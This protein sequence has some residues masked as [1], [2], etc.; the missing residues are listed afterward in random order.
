MNEA[1]QISGN[2]PPGELERQSPPAILTVVLLYAVFASLWILLSDKAVEWLFRSPAQVILAS[3]LKGWFFVAV[4][5]LLLYGLMRRLLGPRGAPATPEEVRRSLTLPLVLTALAI[6][7][8]TAGGIYHA[9]IHHQDKQAARLQAI[10]DL[11]TRQIADWLKERQG[12]AEF[13]LTSRS[14]AENY[15]RWRDRGEVASRDRLLSRLEEYRKYNAFQSVLL[16]DEQGKCLWCSEG[17]PPEI[18]SLL[19]AI[20]RQASA[21]GRIIRLGPYRDGAGRLHL[22]YA[23]PLPALNGRP[24]PVVVLHLDPQSHLVPILQNWPVPSTSSE[25]LLFRRDGDKILFLNELR[26]QAAAPLKLRLPLEE[27]NLLAARLLRGEIKLGH[28]AKGVDYRGVPVLGVIR[29]VPGTN[30]FLVAKLD[31]AEVYSEAMGDA[32]WIALAGLLALFVAA[33]GAFLYRQRQE[34]AFSQREHRVQ[35]EKLRALQ[36]LEVIADG[37]TDAIFVKDAEGR[38]LLFN[39]EAARVTGRAPEQVLGRDDRTIFPPDQAELIRANDQRV[40]ADDRVVTFQEDLNT[41]DGEASFWATKGPI[42][43]ADARVVGIF[44]ISRDITDLQ[45]ATKNLQENEEKYRLLAENVS[46]VIWVLDL[47]KER[48]RYVSPSVERMGGYTSEEMLSLE[49]PTILTPESLQKFQRVLPE[50]IQRFQ[51][52]YVEFFTD[53]IEQLHQD[54]TR[55]LAE[56]NTR[57]VRN[58]T[59]GHLELVGVTRDITERKKSEQALREKDELLRE[60]SAMAH[61][62]GWS[63]NPI[64]GDGTWTDETARIHD[65]EPPQE[66][67]VPFGLDFFHGE[68]R[69]EL[70]KAVREAG[71]DGRPFDLEL[72]M[73][74]AKGLRKWVRILG[75]PIRLDGRV[76]RVRGT[77]QDITERKRAERERDLTVDLL[78]LVNESHSQEEMIRRAATFFQQQSGF[79]AVGI[80]LQE[81]DD[82]PY[83]EARGFPAEFVLAENSICARSN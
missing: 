29:A 26:H 40:M 1:N 24:S 10:A 82:Y 66:I 36:L 71:E 46:D 14:W 4:T 17:E 41:I 45:R 78:R 72:E 80:R 32:L 59:S 23:A 9:I 75:Y 11:K 76:I 18:D 37:S 62:G 54:G 20:A 8:L 30:W 70:E 43:D 42:H 47:V 77:I 33:A 68:W 52:G 15:H 22:D 81:E 39:R 51:E 73:V 21:L 55:I 16:L 2:R 74:T 57:L 83:F 53:E 69:R 31:R 6:I 56:V 60:M 35:A 50:R 5:A 12:D 49:L 61:I 27:K 13:V 7:A 25:T 58:P 19:S 64:T 44:G 65:L 3:T 48:F 79:E 63:F 28:P 67:S 34:L 38:Y